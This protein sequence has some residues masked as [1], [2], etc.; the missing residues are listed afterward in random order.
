MKDGLFSSEYSSVFLSSDAA[1]F[2]SQT[3]HGGNLPFFLATQTVL[4]AIFTLL[5]FALPFT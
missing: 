1:Q 5:F 3:V 2:E 4:N